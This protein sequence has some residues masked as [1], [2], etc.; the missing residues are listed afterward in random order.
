MF[1]DSNISC[2]VEQLH[3]FDDFDTPEKFLIN[4]LRE[5]FDDNINFAFVIFSDVLNPKRKLG[6]TKFA[7]YIKDSSLGNVVKTKIKTNPNSGNKIRVWVWEVDRD[8][9]DVW[10]KTALADEDDDYWGPFY[11]DDKSL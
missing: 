6:G 1:S 7:K 9:L 2:G 4:S 5:R 3:D 11:E 8:K 10:Y